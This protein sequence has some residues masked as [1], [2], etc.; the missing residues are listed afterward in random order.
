VKY[1]KTIVLGLFLVSLLSLLYLSSFRSAYALTARS[2][3]FETGDFSGW[4][5]IHFEEDEPIVVSNVTHWGS[6][7][8]YNRNTSTVDPGDCSVTWWG[9]NNEATI[10]PEF[11]ARGYFRFYNVSEW[12]QHAW[13][14]TIILMNSNYT[15]GSDIAICNVGIAHW[16]GTEYHW[17]IE[18]YN[19]SDLSIWTATAQ[20]TID[21]SYWYCIEL[22]SYIDAS[23]GWYNL[24]IDGVSVLNK[25]GMDTNEKGGVNHVDFGNYNY[26]PVYWDDCEISAY[27]I[28]LGSGPPTD[29]YTVAVA[30]GGI[31]AV[32]TGSWL[33]WWWRRIKKTRTV[34][35]P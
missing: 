30:T 35:I 20:F 3:G 13:T 12:E 31:V 24:W 29:V 33:F 1:Y 25:T 26:Y 6:Y 10:E 11:W 8:A 16:E 2:D 19:G 5:D 15:A 32:T 7:A 23:V 28:G 18:G 27:Y 21:E 22:G 9:W 4:D 14:R 17:T 34:T